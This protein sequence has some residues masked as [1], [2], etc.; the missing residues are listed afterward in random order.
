M[1]KE[2]VLREFSYVTEH[3]E[4]YALCENDNT[5]IPYYL[6]NL[7]SG[8]VTLFEIFEEYTILTEYLLKNGIRIISETELQAI[9][10]EFTP[11]KRR[12]LSMDPDFELRPRKKK[13]T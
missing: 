13:K 8:A 9:L 5:E 10:A 11:E 6:Y 1:N 7:R 3:I 2:D 4:N 12:L